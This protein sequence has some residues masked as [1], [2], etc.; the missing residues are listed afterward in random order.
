MIDSKLH[1]NSSR[2]FAQ[3][4]QGLE[5]GRTVTQTPESVKVAEKFNYLHN[6]LNKLKNVITLTSDGIRYT[7]NKGNTKFIEYMQSLPSIYCQILKDI[8]TAKYAE[9]CKKFNITV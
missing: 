7:D 8:D 6:T 3:A 2:P 5:I 4:I 1:L 9:F